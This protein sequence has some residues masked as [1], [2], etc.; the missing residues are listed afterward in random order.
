METHSIFCISGNI[1]K[2]D[3]SGHFVFPVFHAAFIMELFLLLKKEIAQCS[4]LT[5]DGALNLKIV[6]TF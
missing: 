2:V 4:H 3:C 5:Y 6:G 1:C